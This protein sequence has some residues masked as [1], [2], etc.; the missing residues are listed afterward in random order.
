M[1]VGSYRGSSL[2]VDVGCGRLVHNTIFSGLRRGGLSVCG[3]GVRASVTVCG[4]KS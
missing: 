4:A 1:T 3:L 2:G